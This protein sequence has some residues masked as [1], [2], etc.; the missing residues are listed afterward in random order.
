MRVG[1]DAQVA[2][3]I[4][5][6]FSPAFN[7]PAPLP[8]RARLPS[9]HCVFVVYPILFRCSG[10]DWEDA[11]PFPHITLPSCRYDSDNWF[12]LHLPQEGNHRYDGV[13][14]R[15]VIGAT[16]SLPQS[17]IYK[18]STACRLTFK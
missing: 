18:Q 7:A 5:L 2:L 15:D 13:R 10:L 9:P 12:V 3:Q 14:K 11:Y 4:V 17:T 1:S 6:L 16:A 8:A